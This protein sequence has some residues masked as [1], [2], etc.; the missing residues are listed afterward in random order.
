MW[1]DIQNSLLCMGLPFYMLCNF[2]HIL[3]SPPHDPWLHFYS[4]NHYYPRLDVQALNIFLY[5]PTNGTFRTKL[6]LS[7]LLF[8]LEALLAIPLLNSLFLMSGHMMLSIS[9]Q[10]YPELMKLFLRL[11]K[12]PYYM[13]SNSE[14]FRI[15][16]LIIMLLA[17][18]LMIFF[19]MTM[20]EWDS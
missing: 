10:G 16:L 12:W 3:Y 8:L 17:S 11:S 6:S 13:S 14:Q 5:Y 4:W 18:A 7:L 2:A 1:R 19:F 20:G 9:W 15:S